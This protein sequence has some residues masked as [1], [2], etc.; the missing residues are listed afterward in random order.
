MSD[1]APRGRRRD[2]PP[3]RT[4]TGEAEVLR[5]FLDYLR[6]SIASKVE[7]TPEPEVRNAQVTSGTNL[8]GLLNHLAHVEEGIFLGRRT[9]NWQATFQC[10]DSDTRE[11][12]VSRY[13]TAVERANTVLDDCTDLADT[14]PG[15]G[16]GPGNRSKTTRALRR[17]PAAP[18]R[19]S[20]CRI[21]S[22]ADAACRERSIEVSRI[23]FIPAAGLG[24]ASCRQ[25]SAG[26]PARPRTRASPERRRRGAR[27]RGRT[28]PARAP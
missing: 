24:E 26:S 3:P 8:L 7:T 23:C 1:P 16:P 14:P 11:D 25:G 28:G 20:R 10:D 9:T 13:R 17:R 19:V 12:V 21:R 22:I 5:G 2:T 6:A 15:P 18:S 4:G 27:A